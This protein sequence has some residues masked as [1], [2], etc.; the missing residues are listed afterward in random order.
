MA[1][2]RTLETRETTMFTFIKRLAAVAVVAGGLAGTVTAGDC[3]PVYKKVVCYQTVV[4]TE[5]REVPYEKVVTKYDHCGK[6]YCVTV[7]CYQTVEVTVT[8]QVPVVKY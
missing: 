1:A 8:K 3:G 4:S 2:G 5:T 7:T 6:P